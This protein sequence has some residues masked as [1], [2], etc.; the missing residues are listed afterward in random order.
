MD[1]AVNRVFLVKI[2]DIH[3][4]SHKYIGLQISRL[5]KYQG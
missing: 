2:K 3:K 4:Y 5:E 1:T